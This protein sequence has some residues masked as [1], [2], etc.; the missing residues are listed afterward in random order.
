VIVSR[1]ATPGLAHRL[2]E[3]LRDEGPGPLVRRTFGRRA[4]GAAA[5]DSAAAGP[6]PWRE[7]VMDYCRIAGIPVVEVGA[8]DTAEALAA[9]A[10]AAPELAIH[11]GAGILRRA[12]LAIPRLG[13]LNAHMGVLPHYRGMNVAEWSRLEGR[14]V[15]CS[16]HLI[17][18]GIDTGDIICCRPVPLDGVHGVAQLRAAVNEAQIRLLG[19]VVRHV[20]ATGAL[21]PRRPQEP[22]EGRQ[23]FAMHGELRERLEAALR[24]AA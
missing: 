6:P 2:R 24:A 1:G 14:T 19:E 11:A 17:D 23:Y 20:L 21:P 16:V 8:L 18:E 22:A 9:V 4:P 15:G 13:T 5:P 10:A 12:I 7:S 3:K